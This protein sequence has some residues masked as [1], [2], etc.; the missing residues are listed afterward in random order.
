[1]SN[2]S[3]F[4]V[5][6]DKHTTAEIAL[7]AAE[8]G[9]IVFDTDKEMCYEY[10]DSAWVPLTVGGDNN[11]MGN[12]AKTSYN[13]LTG[14]TKI[15]NRPSSISSQSYAIQVRG[16]QRDTTGT[17]KSVD[18]EADIRTTGGASAYGVSG[19]AKV[20]GGV[21]A[22]AST[23]IGCYGQARVDTSGVLAGASF[24]VGLY[25]LI[26]ASPAMTATH[27]TSCWLDSHQ[28]N[29]VTG[30][31]DL[32]YMTNNGAAQMDQAIYIYGGNK[33]TNLL[34]LSTV[35]GMVAATA[36]TSGTSKKIK[37]IIDGT[38]YYLN[39]YTG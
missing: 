28:A 35:S 36:T 20:D 22:T 8:T 29:A 7:L 4:A 6:P 19:V 10:I 32:L 9:A 17:Y 5:I 11:V 31:H 24:L 1:M 26:E 39:A 34:R 2:K 21:T 16:Y 25:G 33:I 13:K 30:E 14:Y 18:S 15:D 23:V 3:T 12:A 27:V 37:I 38:T